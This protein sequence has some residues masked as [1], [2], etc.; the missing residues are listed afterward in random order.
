MRLDG[1][2]TDYYCRRMHARQLTAKAWLG[3]GTF[4]AKDQTHTGAR[5]AKSYAHVGLEE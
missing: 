3:Y 5:K 1:M 4:P 2:N